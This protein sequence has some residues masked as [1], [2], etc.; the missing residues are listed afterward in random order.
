ML[1]ASLSLLALAAIT[2]GAMGCGGSSKPVGSASSAATSASSPSGTT[3]SVST[4][5]MPK[6]TIA[7]GAPLTRSRWIAKADRIC[8][9]VNRKVA[10]NSIVSAADYARLLP[11]FAAYYSKEAAD[12]SRLVPPTAMA[13]DDEQI[14]DGLRLLSEY[15]IKSGERFAASDENGGHQLFYAALIAQHQVVTIAKRDG[16]RQCTATT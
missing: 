4:L 5:P 1:Q 8:A 7:T 14:V 11:Q 9:P 12:L 15:L 10:G 3:A 13:H 6:L 16:F 2:V